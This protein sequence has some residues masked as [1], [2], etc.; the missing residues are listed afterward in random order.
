MSPSQNLY[1][2][3]NKIT[4]L[5]RLNNFI[6]YPMRLSEF[7][8]NAIRLPFRRESEWMAVGSINASIQFIHYAKQTLVILY[9][10]LSIQK[11]DH[12]QSQIVHCKQSKKVYSLYT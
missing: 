9:Y 5:I 2:V 8:R 11:M 1:P 4:A 6:I 3:T 12:D 7:G 10:T